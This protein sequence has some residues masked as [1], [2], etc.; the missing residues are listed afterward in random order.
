MGS[1]IRITI[2][3]FLVFVLIFVGFEIQE[4]LADIPWQ[5]DCF[6]GTECRLDKDCGLYGMCLHDKPTRSSGECQCK[7]MQ[8]PDWVLVPDCKEG[9]PCYQSDRACGWNGKCVS[10]PAGR[11][12]TFPKDFTC[13]CGNY[14]GAFDGPR[15]WCQQK[16]GEWSVCSNGICHEQPNCRSNEDCTGIWKKCFPYRPIG[17]CVLI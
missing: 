8:D 15:D 4:N 2:M 17:K 3:K 14:C 10:N 7:Y 11:D 9:V 12:T 1:R 13:T 6:D 5:Q 16:V